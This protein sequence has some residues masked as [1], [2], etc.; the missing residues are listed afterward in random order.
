MTVIHRIVYYKLEV[1]EAHKKDEGAFSRKRACEGRVL[2]DRVAFHATMQAENM[3][4][5]RAEARS[6]QYGADG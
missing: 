1:K 5:C 2:S 3:G 6:G 4:G